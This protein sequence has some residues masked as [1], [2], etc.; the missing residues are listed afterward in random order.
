MGLTRT[1][2]IARMAPEHEQAVAGVFAESDADELPHLLGVTSRH[3]YRFHELYVHLI[4]AED[5]IDSRLDR[6]RGNELFQDVNNKLKP[7]I[8]AYDPVT[9]RG[10]RDA[11]A[12]EFYSW[13][14]T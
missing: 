5:G 1:L 2:I 12:S 4:E 8:Q 14:R 3:L 6:A 13:N 7:Y 11:M 10:P 9:W